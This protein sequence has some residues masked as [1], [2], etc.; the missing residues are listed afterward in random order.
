[1]SQHYKRIFE[2]DETKFQDAADLARLLGDAYTGLVGSKAVDY[3]KVI[4]NIIADP[5]LAA[6]VPGPL[7]SDF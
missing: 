7:S 3:I 4:V 6:H 2:A 5:A 1:M